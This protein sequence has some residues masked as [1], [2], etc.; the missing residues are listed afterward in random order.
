MSGFAKYPLSLDQRLLELDLW[1]QDVATLNANLVHTRDNCNKEHGTGIVNCTEHLAAIITH[2]RNYYLNP[3]P[4]RWHSYRHAYQKE[5][6]SMFTDER[7]TMRDIHDK[8]HAELRQHMK[9]DMCTPQPGDPKLVQNYKLTAS[10]MIDDNESMENVFAFYID[11]QYKASIVPEAAQFCQDLEKARTADERVPLYIKFYCPQVWT[12]S[13]KLAAFKAKYSR[14]FQEGV[15]HDTVV[16]NMRKEAEDSKFREI[17]GLKHRLVD[18]QMAQ[19]A[20][21]KDK[22]RKEEKDRKMKDYNPDTVA[23]SFPNCT[24]LVD[25]D[26]EGSIACALCDWLSQRAPN[27]YEYFYCSKEHAE[28]DF[29]GSHSLSHLTMLANTV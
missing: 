23:C 27:R 22:A 26:D 7:C 9:M 29:V 20:H 13:S 6:G 24:N 25:L 5:L 16:M 19:S 18:L 8:A 14:Q 12:E 1:R 17:S 2:Y 28:Q 4:G 3:N 11:A 10:H 21:L 15:P